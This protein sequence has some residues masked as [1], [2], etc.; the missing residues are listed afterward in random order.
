MSEDF[1]FVMDNM[2]KEEAV[3]SLRES[4][5]RLEDKMIK[6]IAISGSSEE[7]KINSI[8][9][10]NGKGPRN[11]SKMQQYQDQ[12]EKKIATSG[13]PNV[14]TSEIK[15]KARKLAESPKGLDIAAFQKKYHIYVMNVDELLKG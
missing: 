2:E 11:K 14:I 4:E 9:P 5:Q 8:K 6:K 15:A 3:K 12:E 1:N 7:K 10:I 13:S